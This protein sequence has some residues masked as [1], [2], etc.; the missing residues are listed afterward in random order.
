MSFLTALN[1]FNPFDK[2]KHTKL[3]RAYLVRQA[4]QLN[5][6]LEPQTIEDE[7]ALFADLIAGTRLDG[8]EKAMPGL[9][10]TL[11]DAV[12]ENNLFDLYPT[13]DALCQLVNTSIRFQLD[14][15]EVADLPD[16]GKEREKY[17]ITD[18]AK[19]QALNKE[20][21]GMILSQVLMRKG[22]ER[23]HRKAAGD[24]AEALVGFSGYDLLLRRSRRA[25]VVF[26]LSVAEFHHDEVALMAHKKYYDTFGVV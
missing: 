21:M 7:I 18:E 8:N 9:M 10:N 14:Q 12:R 5:V 1:L 23:Q 20:C 13:N 3:M 2:M 4:R 25:S 26:T 17:N 22:R 15:K 6:L 24:I 19:W 11:K 16:Y